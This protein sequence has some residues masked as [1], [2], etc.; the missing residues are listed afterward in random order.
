MKSLGHGRTVRWKLELA[1][2]HPQR[3]CLEILFVLR[4][5]LMALRVEPDAHLDHIILD[6]FAV[7]IVVDVPFEHGVSREKTTGVLRNNLAGL[8][9][10]VFGESLDLDPLLGFLVE[11]EQLA[12]GV[13]RD[14]AP[15]FSCPDGNRF[16]APIFGQAARHNRPP[17]DVRPFS[18]DG[19]RLRLD[20]Q[21]RRAE[22]ILVGP[23]VKVRKRQWR[24]EI[25]R[26]AKR[27]ALVHPANYRLDFRLAQPEVVLQV[28]NAD[29]A[30]VPI[31]RH[32]A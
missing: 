22:V 20:H 31:G 25:G 1:A 7:R 5:L 16:H 2:L 12:V 3:V 26:V 6:E 27:H 14:T 8:A 17:P 30:V 18:R 15:L 21:V 24:R 9:E 11:A 10:R 29:V 4:L 13:V 19:V 23:L 28:L 32:L